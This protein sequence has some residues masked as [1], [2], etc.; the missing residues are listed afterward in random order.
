MYFLLIL[1]K[2]TRDAEIDIDNDLST[3]LMEKLEKGIKNRKKGKPVR[4]VFD[5]EI[6]PILLTYLVK[7]LEL[8]E[9]DNLIAGGRIHNFKDFMI[10]PTRYLIKKSTRK[11]PFVHP[12]LKNVNKVSDV[13]SK[14]RRTCST[15]HI[16][17]MIV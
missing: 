16:I 9:K 11:R 4:F 10:S 2:V 8:S 15:S 7:R 5:K 1:L 17:P 6:D 3:S 14:K 12:A 13:V